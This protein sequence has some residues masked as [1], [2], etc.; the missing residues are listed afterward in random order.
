[1]VVKM[2]N[3]K[4]SPKINNTVLVTKI[5]RVTGEI[6]WYNYTPSTSLFN[7]TFIVGRAHIVYV[8]VKKFCTTDYKIS[9]LD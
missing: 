8:V 5:D 9:K 6:Y 7:L 1:M 4:S 3:L 2:C